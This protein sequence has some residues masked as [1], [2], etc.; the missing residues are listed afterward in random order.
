MTRRTDSS[1]SSSLGEFELLLLLAVLRLGDGAH[2]IGLR[3][4]I[5]EKANR[6]VSR[7][8]LYATLARL[9]EKGFLDWETEEVGPSRGG[10][11]R[12][13][14]RVTRAGLEAARASHAAIVRLA[15]GLGEALGEA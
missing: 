10:I 1:G 5:E 11:P 8:A 7:G 15:S 12:R 3:R 4:E 13:R 9:E 2:A 14:F 6:S